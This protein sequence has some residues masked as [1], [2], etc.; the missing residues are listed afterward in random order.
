MA[1]DSRP[2]WTQAIAT[3]NAASVR[4]DGPLACIG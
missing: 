2:Q 3:K 4:M 1:L